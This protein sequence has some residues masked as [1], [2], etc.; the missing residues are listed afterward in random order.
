MKWHG[1]IC[2]SIRLHLQY[3]PLI[4][5]RGER[6]HRARFRR[7]GVGTIALGIYA[8]VLPIPIIARLNKTVAKKA[9]VCAVFAVE[10][11]CARCSSFCR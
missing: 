4:P 5:S 11:M 9:G 7:M 8:I 3:R 10:S 2:P 1:N 6:P